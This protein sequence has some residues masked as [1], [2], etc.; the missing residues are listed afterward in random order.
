MVSV[1]RGRH[2]VSLSL[3]LFCSP[4][5]DEL[6][7]EGVEALQQKKGFN[8]KKLGVQPK[9]VIEEWKMG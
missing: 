3:S 6:Y 5:V 2:S 7:R 4:F 1:P 9:A 8:E